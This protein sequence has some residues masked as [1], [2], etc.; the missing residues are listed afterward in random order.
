MIET[1]TA[2]Y[3]DGKFVPDS[4]CDL[5]EG[6]RVVVSVQDEPRKPLSDDEKSRLMEQMIERWRRNPI[7]ADA[8]QFTRDEM[9]E[10]R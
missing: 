4:P 8:P 6:T 7:P 2:V 10:R 9:H 5:P 1:L 3:E